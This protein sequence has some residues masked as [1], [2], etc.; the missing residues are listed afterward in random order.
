MLYSLTVMFGRQ[1]QPKLRLDGVYYNVKVYTPEGK[2]TQVS[3]GHVDDH[4]ESEVRVAFAK[5]IELYTNDPQTVFSYRNP[6]EAVREIISP[7]TIFTVGELIRT[8]KE[9]AE[10]NLR[11]T[12]EGLESPDMTK[13]RRAE[14]FL[15][16]YSNWKVTSFGPDQFRKVQKNL[17]DYEYMAGKTSKRYTRR[18]INDTINYI[19]AIWKWGLGRQVVRIENVQS[20]NEVKPLSIGQDNVYENHKRRRITEEEFWKVVNVV[21]PGIGGMLKLVWYT[22]MR[23]FEVC[24]MRPLD[25]LT[26]DPDCWI[27]IPGRD[28]S[29]LGNYKTTR[30]ERVRVIPLTKEPQSVLKARIKNLDPNEYI[31]KP[32]EAPKIVAKKVR[33]KYDHNTFCRACKRGCKRAGVEVF[34]P[35][36]LRRSVAT[37]TR[38]IM[39]KEAAKVLLGHTKTDTTDIYLLE[40]VQEAMKVA[41]L[42]ASR[43]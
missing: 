16:P 5:W 36:D 37:G 12:R 28:I 26:D 33:E 25:I 2:R 4:P 39:C 23:P 22:A 9:R 17:V 29:P 34:V 27:Y 14:K 21:N 3:F 41:K 10:K 32:N 40:E 11:P 6:Y 13:I 24:D 30:F 43:T 18:G 42:L 1:K 20:L 8:Y 31:F 15:A 19:K 38:E 35:Y 7:S